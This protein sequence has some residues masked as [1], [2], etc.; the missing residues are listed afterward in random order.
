M[1]VQIEKSKEGSYRIIS[2]S[3]NK[4]PAL[5]HIAGLLK[6]ANRHSDI[7]IGIYNLPTQKFSTFQKVY[8]YITKRT[9]TLTKKKFYQWKSGKRQLKKKKPLNKILTEAKISYNDSDEVWDMF[10]EA[11][12]K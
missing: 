6:D 2:H 12:T 9:D 5:E 1:Q 10:G 8:S 7:H 4:H 11:L 3:N